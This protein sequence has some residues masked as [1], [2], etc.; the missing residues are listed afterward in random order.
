MQ[1]RVTVTSLLRRHKLQISCY[2]YK[3]G[4]LE[5]LTILKLHLLEGRGRRAQETYLGQLR[6]MTGRCAFLFCAQLCATG[7]FHSYAHTQTDEYKTQ[8]STYFTATEDGNK[9]QLVSC[10]W[11]S[12]TTCTVN[13][14]KCVRYIHSLRS[15]NWNVFVPKIHFNFP[16]QWFAPGFGKTSERSISSSKKKTWLPARGEQRVYLKYPGYLLIDVGQ[17]SNNSTDINYT[18]MFSLFFF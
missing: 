8:Y 9:K 5:T 17:N 14:T 11:W 12:T 6:T 13:K 1:R 16:D 3:G 10:T 18:C 2:S 15:F 4:C 7:F